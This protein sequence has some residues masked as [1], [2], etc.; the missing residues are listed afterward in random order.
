MPP[1]QGLAG[2]A[3]AGPCLVDQLLVRPAG[4]RRQPLTLDHGV[5]HYSY[6]RA[7]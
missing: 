3:L 1:G 4:E 2:L 7:C 5:V 6:L